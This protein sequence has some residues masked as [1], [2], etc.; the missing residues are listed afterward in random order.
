MKMMMVMTVCNDKV[1]LLDHRCWWFL[2]S[3]EVLIVIFCCVIFQIPKKWKDMAGIV[4]HLKIKFFLVFYFIQ[5]LTYFRDGEYG[6]C[7]LQPHTTSSPMIYCARPGSRMWEV[8]RTPLSLWLLSHHL[9]LYG[10]GFAIFIS[11]DTGSP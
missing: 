11:M 6:G 10:Y 4:V 5:F 3:Q 7:F 2:R 8:I 9:Y 1:K